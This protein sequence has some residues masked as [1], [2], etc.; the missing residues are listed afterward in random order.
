MSYD[1]GSSE[2]IAELRK[3][4]WTLQKF[5]TLPG[6]VEKGVDGPLRRYDGQP[7][8]PIRYELWEDAWEHD[9]CV[10]CGQMLMEEACDNY[11]IDTGH[12]DGSDWIC[13]PCF[14]RHL[15]LKNDAAQPMRTAAKC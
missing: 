13:P 12:T 8:D 1:S 6:L 10:L 7:Y 5:K 9:H 2:H 3:S 15:S 14:A 4:S 11:A